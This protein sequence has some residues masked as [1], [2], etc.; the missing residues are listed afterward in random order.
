[1]KIIVWGTLLTIY[2]SMAFPRLDISGERQNDD[3]RWYDSYTFFVVSKVH[4]ILVDKLSHQYEKTRHQIV[5]RKKIT[6]LSI[7]RNYRAR[8]YWR[9]KLIDSN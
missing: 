4:T 3:K 2:K 6:E 1:M 7:Q 9:C 8:G 5:E